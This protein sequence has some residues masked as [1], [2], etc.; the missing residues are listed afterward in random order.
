MIS[1]RGHPEGKFDC[2]HHLQKQQMKNK[3]NKHI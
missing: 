3:Q 2:P 1:D